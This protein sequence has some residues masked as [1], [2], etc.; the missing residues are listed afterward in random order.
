MKIKRV[1]G[2]VAFVAVAAGVTVLGASG[3]AAA[4]PPGEAFPVVC[5]NGV[6]YQ[7]VVAG[8]GQF[9]PAHD[10]ASN[11]ILV[12]TAFGETTI[13]VTDPEGNVT[14]E[15]DPPVSKGSSSPPLATT[16]SCTFHVEATEDGFSVVVDGSVTGFV[17]P[18][19]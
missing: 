15:T 16:A 12:P 8:N 14:T 19:R 18:A 5:D 9:T 17:T 7:V 11:S 3:V 4:D 6:T 10:V 13:T 2:R 1:S